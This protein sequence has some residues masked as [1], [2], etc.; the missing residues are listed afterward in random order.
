LDISAVG[1][2]GENI[3]T[4]TALPTAIFHEATAAYARGDFSVQPAEKGFV[5]H[6][7]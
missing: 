3:V 4:A 2:V 5:I 1:E 6:P 7:P